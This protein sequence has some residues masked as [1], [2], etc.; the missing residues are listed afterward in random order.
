MSMSNNF[1]FK[2][3]IIIVNKKTKEVDYEGIF[4]RM[5]P[6]RVSSHLIV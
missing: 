3:F 6:L 1:E 5:A 2:K 4:L